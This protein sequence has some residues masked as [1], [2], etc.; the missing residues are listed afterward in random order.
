MLKQF[1]LIALISFL[2]FSHSPRV[3]AIAIEQVPNPRKING[4]GVSDTAGLLATEDKA[5]LD[6]L[7]SALE[8]KN[9]SE[10]AVVTVPDTSIDSS[11]SSDFG[12]GDSSGGDSGDSW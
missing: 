12:G 8:A 1:L 6:R 4:T 9:G 7:I 11:S 10:I 3:W 5:Q 2:V